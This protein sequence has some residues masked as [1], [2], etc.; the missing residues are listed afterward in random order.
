[1]RTRW[2]VASLTL[3]VVA[4][5]LILPPAASAALPL[6]PDDTWGADGRVLAVLRVGGAVYLGG[7]FTALVPDDGPGLARNHLG[8]LDGATG[9]PTPFNPD[10]NGNVLNMALSPD[11]S[12]LYVVGDFTKVGTVKR[13][14]VAAFSVATGALL[15]WVPAQWPN[16]SVQTVAVMGATVYL[17]GG[18]TKVGSNAR[19]R[20]AAFD[21][22]TGAL[23]PWAP[24]A[25]KSVRDL[26]VLPTRIYV[27]GFFTTIGGVAGRSLAAVDPTTGALFGGV[28]HPGYPILD[29]EMSGTRIFAA[30]GGAGGRALAVT[31]S[32][33]AK[34]WEKKTDGNVQGVG[35]EG[36][37][38]YFGG[39]YFKY[40]GKAVSQLVRVDPTTGVLDQSWLPTSNGF[41]GVFAVDGFGSRLYVG[42]DFD[43]V[44]QTK[45]LHFA[46]FTDGAITNDAD[47]SVSLSDAPDPVSVGDALTYTALVS[48]AGPDPATSTILTDVLPAGVTFVSSSTG[49]A[50][51]SGSRTVT[52]SLGPVGVGATVSP[53]ITVAAGSSG[54][55]QNTVSVVANETDPTPG[56]N[57][58]TASTTVQSVPGVDLNLNV[59]APVTQSVGTQYAYTLTLVNQGG[60]PATAA[61]VADLLPG[62]ASF[63]SAV[64][65]Q[66]SCTGQSTVSCSLGAMAFNA[67]ATVTITVTA[68]ASPMTL[69]N[70]AT[71]SDPA[72]DPDGSDNAVTTYTTVRVPSA[73]TTPPAKTG[74]QMFD[75]DHNGKVDRAV[76]T[77]GEPI[78]TCPAPCTAGWTLTDVPSN[79]HLLGVSTS[80]S[81]A[82]LTIAEGADDADTSVGQF[83]I[84]LSSPNAIQ[85]AAGNHATFAASAPADAAS[86]VPIAFRH[87]HNSNNSA[88]CSGTSNTTTAPDVCDELTSEWSEALDPSSIPSTTT[89]TLSDPLG[90]GNDTVTIPGFFA[91]DFDGGG[92]T[93]VTQDGATASWAGTKV[94]FNG[95]LGSDYLNIRV[96]G[97]CTGNGCGALGAGPKITVTYIPSSSIRDLAGNAAAGQFVK[98]Q[99]ITLF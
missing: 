2:I 82:T 57:S 25:N 51:A 37:F 29:L 4:A 14:R 80:G 86:P 54:T 74:A 21:A 58:S 13:K 10:L 43:H 75:D 76:V 23:L 92:D 16:S 42:G 95:P 62:D 46:Q 97:A 8:A 85:D 94:I 38:A 64:A 17:G 12:V 49:C 61:T 72:F 70:A 53:T 55:V 63:V 22:T 93:Y 15:P 73:D 41:L 59:S 5:G 47:L 87:Q 18:F 52:C 19:L 30:G 66:G 88:G 56:N 39:H 27:G 7:E 9:H 65:S 69:T 78:A 11:G 83:K 67:T 96:W 3:V 26:I 6:L 24:G 34:L 20:L 89:L 60:D 33:G 90:P 91:G 50:Y 68:P 40:D 35:V 77:F 36:S 28:Y 32:A 98:P 81:Q 99:K 79:G 45:Q 71:A 1:M 44:S 84:E 48:N 31:V